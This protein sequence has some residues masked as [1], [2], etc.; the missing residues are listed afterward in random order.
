MQFYAWKKISFLKAPSINHTF[1]EG[2][3][4]PDRFVSVCGERFGGMGGEGKNDLYCHRCKEL[5]PI[6]E[7]KQQEKERERVAELELSRSATT[8]KIN[9]IL[10]A[11]PID[12]LLM[13]LRELKR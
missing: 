6:L 9:M 7:E 12:N 5:T 8:E 11:M 3:W 1:P 10:S 4:N 2:Y 13:L